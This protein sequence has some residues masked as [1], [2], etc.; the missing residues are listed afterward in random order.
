MSTTLNQVVAIARN[1]EAALRQEQEINSP[2][3]VQVHAVK[4]A[5]RNCTPARS[6]CKNCGKEHALARNLCPTR[7]D[8]CHACGKKGHWATVCLTIKLGQ[9]RKQKARHVNAIETEDSHDQAGNTEE[10]FD[11][12]TFDIINVA[13]MASRRDEAYVELKVRPPGQQRTLP[14]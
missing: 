14:I 3:E 11:Q 13:S 12:V 1:H 8:T 6:L 9:R 4:N 2:E 5:H 10:H 7:N